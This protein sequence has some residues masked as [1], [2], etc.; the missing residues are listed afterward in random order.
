MILQME[1]KYVLRVVRPDYFTLKILVAL[2]TITEFKMILSKCLF[3]S[4]KH[5]FATLKA[6]QHNCCV[7]L[8]TVHK[9]AEDRIMFSL[10]RFWKISD[11]QI[12]PK[13]TF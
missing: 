9:C 7:R 8:I 3:S 6:C 2:K 1:P 12:K 10:P 5:N 4:G 11:I 13:D